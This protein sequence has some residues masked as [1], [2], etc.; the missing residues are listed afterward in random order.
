[1]DYSTEEALGDLEPWEFEPTGISYF[2]SPELRYYFRPIGRL[3]KKSALIWFFGCLFS[4][5]I[6]C[7]HT[8]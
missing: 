7:Q 8:I 2:I 3:K 5:K 6:F 1:L 4:F